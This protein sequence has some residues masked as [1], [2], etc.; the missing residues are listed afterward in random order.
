MPRSTLRYQ[1]QGD[2]YVLY[3]V[4]PDG[5]DNNG[6]PVDDPTRSPSTPS[7]RHQVDQQS[8]GD[9]VAGVNR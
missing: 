3:S 4:G 9:I 5:M 7:R 6:T 8:L 1:I 2:K